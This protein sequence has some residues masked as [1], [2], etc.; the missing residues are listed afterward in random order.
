M[1]ID[2]CI[3]MCIDMCIDMCVDMCPQRPRVWENNQ[4]VLKIRRTTHALGILLFSSPES[5]VLGS[6]QWAYFPQIQKWIGRCGCL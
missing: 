5:W 3:G 4:F 2:M 1:R 6:K